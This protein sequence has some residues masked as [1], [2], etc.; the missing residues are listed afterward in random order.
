MAWLFNAHSI[1]VSA[2][3]PPRRLCFAANGRASKNNIAPVAMALQICANPAGV[4][5]ATTASP[6]RHR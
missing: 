1:S 2:R 4:R 6:L 3:Q 5:D